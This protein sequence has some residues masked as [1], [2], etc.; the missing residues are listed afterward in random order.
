MLSITNPFLANSADVYLVAGT[1]LNLSFA[2][3]DV[4]DSLFIDGVS[5][6]EGTWGATGNL[7]A[8]FQS[9]LITGTGLLEVTTLVVPGV[10]GDYNDDGTVDAADYAVWRKNQGT[11]NTLPN[12]NGI[13]GT[14]GT[15]HYDLW[16]ANFGNPPGSGSGSGALAAVPEPSTSLLAVFAVCGL[17]AAA[18]RR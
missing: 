13:G 15:A 2:G 9:S 5:Q 14:I 1:T 17:L 3:T 7:A 11:T 18:I 6:A 8:D 10:P 16:V 4:I 12:D